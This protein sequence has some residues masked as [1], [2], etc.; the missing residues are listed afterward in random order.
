MD[1]ATV[2]REDITVLQLTHEHTNKQTTHKH[3][4]MLYT[5]THTQTHKH[6]DK[7]KQTQILTEKYRQILTE[8]YRQI[9]IH[10]KLL[11]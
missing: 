5:N 6:R 3:T 11:K 1:I 8:K 7:V 2:K 4:E 9:Y 10:K